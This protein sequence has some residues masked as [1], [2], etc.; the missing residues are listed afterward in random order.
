MFLAFK[1]C[2]DNYKPDRATGGLMCARKFNEEP[3]F[4]LQANIERVRQ[5]LGV[6][7]PVVPGAF[8]PNREFLQAT[9]SKRRRIISDY[10]KMKENYYN[11]CE[12]TMRDY[13]ELSKNVCRLYPE[14][15]ANYTDRRN[16]ESLCYQAYCSNGKREPFCYKY[17]KEKLLVHSQVPGTGGT[18]MYNN[19]MVGSIYVVVIAYLVNQMMLPLGNAE[20]LNGI[21]VSKYLS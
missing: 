2:S 10:K 3:G 6:K 21:R 20:C 5:Q 1:P 18:A 9:K 11:N 19:L 8:M 4:C 14:I 16:M 7:T 13:N 15:T 17:T 12:N